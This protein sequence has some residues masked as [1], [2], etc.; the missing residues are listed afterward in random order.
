MKGRPALDLN[1]VDPSEIPVPPE[2]VRI[3]RLDF[4]PLGDGKRLKVEIDLTPFQQPPSL[5]IVVEDS[6]GAEVASTSIIEAMA[7]RMSF[8]LH[9]RQTDPAGIYRAQCTV[10]YIDGPKADEREQTLKLK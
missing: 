2:D 6:L 9:L 7:P 4:T 1:L 3:R 10:E 8:T 5:H